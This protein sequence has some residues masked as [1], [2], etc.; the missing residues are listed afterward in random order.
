[1]GGFL[2]KQVHIC[3]STAQ[4]KLYNISNSLENPHALMRS[5]YYADFYHY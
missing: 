2:H 3:V 1:M 4:I 5:D